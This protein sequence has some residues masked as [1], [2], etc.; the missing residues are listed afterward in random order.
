MLDP[1]LL[2]FLWYSAALYHKETN[3][4]CINKLWGASFYSQSALQI[5]AIRNIMFLLNGFFDVQNKQS[6]KQ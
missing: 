4:Y 3:V 6:Q 2:N 5:A 1:Y